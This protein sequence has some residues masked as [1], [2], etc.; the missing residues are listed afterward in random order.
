MVFIDN[1]EYIALQ[2]C[3]LT[4]KTNSLENKGNS[5]NP[6]III[7]LLRGGLEEFARKK[8]GEKFGEFSF[9]C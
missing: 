6:L 7:Y 4:K 1:K 9:Y 5:G 3:F 2:R 8:D